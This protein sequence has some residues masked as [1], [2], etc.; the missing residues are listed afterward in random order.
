MLKKIIAAA[1]ASTLAV[2]ALAATTASADAAK[3]EYLGH[4]VVD[5]V[6]V[7]VKGEAK[8]FTDMLNLANPGDDTADPKVETVKENYSSIEV[9]VKNKTGENIKVTGGKVSS[10]LVGNVAKYNVKKGEWGAAAE[11]TGKA[12]ADVAAT[13]LK[14]TKGEFK[15]TLK[16]DSFGDKDITR[17]DSWDDDK[18][19]IT[20]ELTMELTE[21]QF[22]DLYAGGLDDV[23]ISSDLS[24]KLA[25]GAVDVA[26]FF[27]ATA[28]PKDGKDADKEDLDF[29]WTMSEATVT[30]KKVIYFSETYTMDDNAAEWSRKDLRQFVNGG[31]IEF[32]FNNPVGGKDW[33]D[34]SVTFTN[35]NLQNK[36]VETDYTEET[37]TLSVDIPA[38]FAYSDNTNTYPL[39]KVEWALQ[40]KG[41]N[42]PDGVTG[43]NTGMSDAMKDLKIVKVVFTANDKAPDNNGGNNGGLVEDDKNKPSTD[44]KTSSDTKPSTPDNNNS[45]SNSNDNKNPSTGVA[46]AVAP[47]ALAA[48]AAAVVIS[49]KRK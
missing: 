38:N 11:K 2:S 15:S 3:V 17:I 21:K 45:G 13:T 31:K 20:V 39:T 33:V 32:V 19:K 1:A 42:D 34:G 41:S 37:N 14:K 46:M 28:L 7:K 27:T 12:S 43:D 22:T 36:T 25:D 47:V 30:T 18:S 26:S 6:T 8:G 10:E 40:R 49:K 5:Y 24:D 44:D 23:N 9:A 4:D 48:A 16:T 35:S 29:K